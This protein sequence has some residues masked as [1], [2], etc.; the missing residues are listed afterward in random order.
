MSK[1]VETEESRKA[2]EI[3]K[4]QVE[5]ATKETEE[6][7]TTAQATLEALKKKSGAAHGALWW[8]EKDLA[9]AKKFF[10]GRKK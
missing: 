2:A 1:K 7:F 6:K 9:E 8:I 5:T 4:E 10:G 3:Q